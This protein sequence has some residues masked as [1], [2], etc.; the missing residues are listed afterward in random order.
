MLDPAPDGDMV[1]CKSALRHHFFQIPV[2]QRIPQLPPHTQHD[3]DSLK[4][5]PSERRWWA[6]LTVSPYQTLPG[7]LQ[8]IP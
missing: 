8:Q 1:H 2:A 5:P 7:R 3:D 6:R 4:V